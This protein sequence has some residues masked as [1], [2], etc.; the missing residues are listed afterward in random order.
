MLTA[1]AEVSFSTVYRATRE[2]GAYNHAAMIDARNGSLFL[3]WKNSPVDEDT[4]GQ[5]VLFAQ[6]TDGD[7][8]TPTDG[9]TNVLF[10]NVSSAQRPAVGR[11][12]PMPAPAPAVRP[13]SV[14]ACLGPWPSGRRPW[15]RPRP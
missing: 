8:W 15:R 5:R 2:I 4:P 11:T 14:C 3:A 6:S 7:T 12:T 10:P 13:R 9:K 1:P